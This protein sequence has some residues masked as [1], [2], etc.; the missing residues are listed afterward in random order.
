MASHIKNSLKQLP[1][2]GKTIKPRIKEF[3]NAKLLSELPFFEKPIR[4][5]IKQLSTKKLLSKQPFYKQPIK[6]PH[7]KNLSNFK[8]LRGLPFYDIN[9]SRKERA[10]KRY[11][12]TYKVEIINNKNLSD[13]LSVSKNSIKN[14]FDELL[15]EKRG[16]KYV[17]STKIISR[18]L[19]NDNEHKY[20]TVY[21]NSLVKTVINRRYHLKDS[22]EEILNLLDIWIN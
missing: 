2:F 7:A 10:F 19:I 4:T 22:F 17:L 14:L 9:I 8:L 15:R 1:F 13:S 3:T 5:K 6:K 12:E 21:V 16:F 20:S 11:A 18:K